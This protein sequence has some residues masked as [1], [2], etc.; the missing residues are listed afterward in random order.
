MTET[1]ALPHQQPSVSG[2]T[3]SNSNSVASP[4]SVST[5]PPPA[6]VLK[7]PVTPNNKNG[8]FPTSDRYEDETRSNNGHP[9]PP[10]SAKSSLSV[11]GTSPAAL[12]TKSAQVFEYPPYP[13]PPPR[14]SSANGSINGNG[15]TSNGII[16]NG[17]N[18]YSTMARRG[19]N[20]YGYGNGGGSGPPSASLY[21]REMVQPGVEEPIDSSGVSWQMFSVTLHRSNTVGFGIAISFGLDNPHFIS[22]DPVI[23]ISE[24]VPS[25]PAAGL[26]Q[27][28]DRIVAAN[29]IK[30]EHADYATAVA[31]M[32]NSNQ[33]NMIVKRRV[34]VPFI[35]FEQRT[36]KF[37]LSKS[38][39]KDDFGI[40]LGC[41]YY[42]KEITNPKLAEKDPGLKEGDVVLRVNGQ[43]LDN[44]TL[45]E[46]TRLLQRS[47]EKLSL[48]V[49]RDVRRGAPGSRW[50]SQ[51]TV[52]ERLGS[53]SATPRH[54]PTPMHYTQSANPDMLQSA[55]KISA[56]FGSK[57]LSDP[58]FA[59]QQQQQQQQ[60]AIYGQQFPVHPQDQRHQS[61]PR[62]P[63]PG[64]QYFQPN[65]NPYCESPRPLHQ[66]VTV[67]APSQT[68]SICSSPRLYQQNQPNG[69][70]STDFRII[71]FKKPPGS[72]LG[73]RVIGG[74]HV[75]IFVSAVQ[76]DSPAA[77]HGIRIGDKLL[78]V[79]NYSMDRVTREQAVEYLLNM[80]E[81]VTLRVDSAF[82]EFL[83]VRNQQIGDNFFIRTHFNYTPPTPRR[84]ALANQLR[85]LSFVEGDILRVLD[86]LFGGSVGQW[87]VQKL[88]SANG[89]EIKANEEIG[90]IPNG[91][92]ADNLAKT[93]RLE[94]SGFGRSL[95]R[96][97][98]A[99][100]P[101][102]EEDF[103]DIPFPAY[104]RVA[105]KQPTFARPVVLYGPLADVAKQLLLSNFALKFAG[106]G[107]DTGPTGKA[108]A[109]AQVDA[110]M[111]AGKHAVM[112]LTPGSVERLHLAQYAPIVILLES[113][114]RSKVRDLRAK[115]GASTQSARK[116]IEQAAKLKKHHANL[117]T[118]TL[119]VSKEDQWF[120]T[121][122]HTIFT[123]QDRRVWMPEVPPE[124]PLHEMVLFPL[125][126]V[127]ANDSDVPAKSDYATGQFEMR[128]AL[129]PATDTAINRFPEE[130]SNLTMNGGNNQKPGYYAAYAGRGSGSQ[131][132]SPY[133]RYGTGV[134][135]SS[136]PIDPFIRPN[137]DNLN[138]NFNT[139]S[140][141]NKNFYDTATGT[142]TTASNPTYDDVRSRLSASPYQTPIRQQNETARNL[143][144]ESNGKQNYGGARDS[145][146]PEST[147]DYRVAGLSADDKSSYDPPFIDELP[148]RSL[149]LDTE[150]ADPTPQHH[151]N[152]VKEH[153]SGVVDWTGG[154]LTCPESGVELRVPENAIPYGT[155]QHMYVEVCDESPHNPPLGNK[156]ALASPLVVCG[157]QGLKFDIPVELRLPHKFT[158]GDPTAANVVL[159]AGQGNHWTNIELAS[160]PKSDSGSKF[161]SVLVNH[162]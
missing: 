78:A 63:G 5:P 131:N 39:K 41:K 72:S 20:P 147:A 60:N 46:A 88:F 18:P 137:H 127:D 103:F 25:G 53:V 51:N 138:N 6:S 113:E 16:S 136:N 67:A 86:T 79:N 120:D 76:D 85:E 156:E 73:I 27:L 125:P 38:R 54:S 52:Y 132:Y 81:D 129:Y 150:V 110:V 19:Q 116:L 31:I 10:L 112:T 33:L 145:R 124:R 40:V 1:C 143:F 62:S 58:N 94:S 64:Q 70:S 142:T 111:A 122:K 104:E 77:Q 44:V 98:T 84:G 71:S 29:G 146:T 74:N 153:V 56:E 61:M 148:S 8:S 55:R 144:F 157:P 37:T 102:S 3:A 114:S 49:Q 151:Q 24:V 2:S 95:F 119:D 152:Q 162:F 28:N 82:E 65:G 133:N 149:H 105:L 121:L 92:A 75:G 83:N 89:S 12:S 23:Y 118:A 9:G 43:S 87:K 45:E 99:N 7:P 48:V 42:I 11:N 128:N 115:A 22:G 90:V 68:N 109:L 91:K 26:V 21:R 126:A 141:S 158:D 108:V 13:H 69:R 4:V 159:K 30:L 106:V 155:E 15:F 59:L 161:V 134:A 160:S 14:R 93:H 135:T 140:S 123:L 34:P 117:L 32:Q 36:L 107:E 80:G 17:V 100:K 139:G 97:K 96:K 130:L 35:E 101:K 47:R 66:S 154:T 57:R 50:S